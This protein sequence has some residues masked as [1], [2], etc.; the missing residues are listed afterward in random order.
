MKAATSCRWVFAISLT[1]MLAAALAATSVQSQPATGSGPVGSRPGASH[2]PSKPA[3][4]RSP[5]PADTM[6]SVR[7]PDLPSLPPVPRERA[8]ALEERLRRGQ[9]DAPIAQ[10]RISD[11]LEQFHRSSVEGSTGETL[12]EQSAQGMV[13]E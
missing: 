6:Q 11:R 5:N 4:P 3:K 1:S 2:E 10:G 9:M 12:P 8:Q 13:A 7:P